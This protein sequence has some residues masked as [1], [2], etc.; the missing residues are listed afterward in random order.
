MVID[1]NLALIRE[2]CSY[3]RP[4]YESPVKPP[5]KYDWKF[6]D[7]FG[8]RYG[9]LRYRISTL[10]DDP[11]I[12]PWTDVFGHDV[13][14]S[15]FFAGENFGITAVADD[16]SFTIHLVRPP[17]EPVEIFRQT[18]KLELHGL[19]ADGKFVLVQSG[20]D[21]NWYRPELLVISLEG[22][23][24]ARLGEYEGATGCWAGS[25]VPQPGD[26]R[27]IFL[28][29]MTGYYQPAIWSPFENKIETL[30]TNLAGEVWAT[31]DLTGHA[32]ILKRGL[33]ARS[34]LHRLDLRTRKLEA[35]QDLDGV[36]F[37][38]EL[39]S[40]NRVIGMWSV[41]HRFVENIRECDRFISEDFK[42][43]VPLKP[44]RSRKIAGIPC[45]VM[46]E[47]PMHGPCW[48]IF[49]G[50]GMP[51][52]HHSEGYNSRVQT[53]VDHGFQVVYVNTQGCSGY[54]R[55]W[56][57]ATLGN[58][59]FTE[60]EDMRKVRAALIEEGL[61]DDNRTI[62]T[63]DSWGGYM[64]LLAMGTQP[65]LWKMGVAGLPVGDY[66]S[67]HWEASPIIR[68]VNRTFFGGN[69]HTHAEV[70]HRASPLT[71]VGAIKAP[72]LMVAGKYDLLCP[73]KQ[74]VAFAEALRSKGGQCELELFEGAHGPP[75][76]DERIRQITL[77]LEFLLRHCRKFDLESM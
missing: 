46:G 16:E 68:A 52:Y 26:Y 54:G 66:E 55:T 23:V 5:S 64:T 1:P 40:Q 56:R 69:A 65:G 36:V 14:Q 60:L 43:S 77:M 72:I 59:G 13:H 51:G 17:E 74:N 39:D 38:H 21:G 61:V 24:V 53:F 19:S 3:P 63:G 58:I 2:R 33:N 57:E 8:N 30:S 4:A 50:Y 27:I 7:H 34:D 44:W 35:L 41:N 15:G 22:V 6:E 62:I 12:I 48:T 11:T 76:R 37:H 9:R 73:P 42:P 47:P 31:W 71:Y 10:S 29:E 49:D 20:K 28:H 32:L 67:C 25:W 70:Y 18:D 75:D 45:L